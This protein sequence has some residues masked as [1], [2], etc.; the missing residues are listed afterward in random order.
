MI[1]A[2]IIALSWPA[3]ADSAIPSAEKM[4]MFVISSYLKQPL[5]NRIKS[6]LSFGKL[7]FRVCDS[8]SVC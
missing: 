2:S 1:V 5:T 3:E 7:W 4:G 8:S 6:L